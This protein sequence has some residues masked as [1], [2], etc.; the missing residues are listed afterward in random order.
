MSSNS[1]VVV[2]S[3]PLATSY[4]A[5]CTMTSPQS[6][7]R[8]PEHPYIQRDLDDQTQARN[9]SDAS[10]KQKNHRGISLRG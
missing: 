3:L 8:M 9:T 4:G 1:G 6:T 10:A 7:R 5:A 2:G